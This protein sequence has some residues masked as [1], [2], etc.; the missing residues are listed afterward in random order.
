MDHSSAGSMGTSSKDKNESVS[1]WDIDNLHNGYYYNILMSGGCSPADITKDCIVEHFLTNSD[2]GAV[3]VFGNT[4]SGYSDEHK[5]F[6][7]F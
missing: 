7:I 1:N 4:D 3:A 2:G 5:T 6:D